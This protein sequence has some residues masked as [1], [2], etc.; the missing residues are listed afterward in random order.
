MKDSFHEYDID[1][2]TVVRLTEKQNKSFINKRRSNSN[3]TLICF[4]R[5]EGYDI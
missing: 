1:E 5:A 2:K 3:Y 4:L